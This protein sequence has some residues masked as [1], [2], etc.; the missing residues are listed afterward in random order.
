M[1]GAHRS[2]LILLLIFI[3]HNRIE[4]NL[5][6]TTTHTHNTHHIW[7]TLAYFKNWQK[8]EKINWHFFSFSLSLKISNKLPFD[9]QKQ[10]LFCCVFYLFFTLFMN[11]VKLLSILNSILAC[12]RLQSHLLVMHLTKGLS[13]LLTFLKIKNIWL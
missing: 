10:K 13:T 7:N 4:V 6:N 5:K 8:C 9:G 11:S 2:I 3:S 1:L 12:D